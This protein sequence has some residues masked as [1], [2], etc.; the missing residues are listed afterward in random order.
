ER[1]AVTADETLPGT[2]GSFGWDDEGVAAQHTPLIRDGVL[3]A[4]LSDRTS[5][6]AVG[7]PRSGGCARADGY[8]RQP[9]VRMTHVSIEPAAA[10]LSGVEGE[11]QVTVVLE[12][13]LTSRFSR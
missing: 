12:R 1:L 6:A 4:T 3:R 10:V 5:A 9:I 8:T 2:L 11:A 13:S 7:L